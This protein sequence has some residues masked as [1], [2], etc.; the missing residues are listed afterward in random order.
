MSAAGDRTLGQVGYGLTRP[1]AHGDAGVMAVTQ[2]RLR[3]R[4]RWN[5][6][7]QRNGMSM[8]SGLFE[9]QLMPPLHF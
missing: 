3:P 7:N 1:H 2:C 5:G 9:T 4:S 6:E 8:K